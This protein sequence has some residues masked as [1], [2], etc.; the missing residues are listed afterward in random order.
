MPSHC[1]GIEGVKY[2]LDLSSSIDSGGEALP[3]RLRHHWPDM[4][5]CEGWQLENASMA[6]LV[7]KWLH[8]RRFY[9]LSVCTWSI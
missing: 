3:P 8:V 7:Q 5:K 2:V 4:D 9:S 1:F 6:Y